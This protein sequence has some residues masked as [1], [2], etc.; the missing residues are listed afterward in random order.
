MH[1]LPDPCELP[2]CEISLSCDNLLCD[3]NGRPPNPVLLIHVFIPEEGVL[4]KY[5]KT[6]VM[7][8]S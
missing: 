8:V 2:L 6:E 4:I 7:E 1:C 3:G 5:A